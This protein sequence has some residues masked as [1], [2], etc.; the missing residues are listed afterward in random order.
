MFLRVEIPVDNLIL[1][2]LKW[3]SQECIDMRIDSKCG[4]TKVIALYPT[5]ELLEELSN[6]G[7]SYELVTCS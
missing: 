7:I 3:I 6:R 4:K 2:D 1:R 5:G